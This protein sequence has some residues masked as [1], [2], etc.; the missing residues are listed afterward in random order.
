MIKCDNNTY[1]YEC[2]V[3]I[4]KTSMKDEFHS[5][6]KN[7]TWE[8][9]I[10]PAGR[11][12]VKWKWVFKTKFSVD[13][14]PMKYKSSLV[15]KGFSQFQGIDYNE[16][17]APVAKMDSIRLVLAIAASKQ[18]EVHHMDVKISFLHGYL[19]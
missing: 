18:W 15:A 11:K 10:L 9:V 8:L 16:T 1:Q 14:S 5:L 2:E 3:P 4:W 7:D 17:F 12:L 13:G 6:Q 19:K